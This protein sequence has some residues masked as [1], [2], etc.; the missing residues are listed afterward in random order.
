MTD[1]NQPTPGLWAGLLNELESAFSALSG[2]VATLEGDA[3]TA[4]DDAIAAIESKL[5]E[6][7]NWIDHFQ[8][9]PVVGHPAAQQ[10]AQNQGLPNAQ[11]GQQAQEH[12]GNA[13]GA[14]PVGHHEQEPA[15][16]KAS[17]RRR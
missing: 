6:A 5:Q 10:H 11:V 3:R 4:A 15:E 13:Q 14:Q 17:T 8:G 16:P 7:R 9:S 1:P 2:H 12:A